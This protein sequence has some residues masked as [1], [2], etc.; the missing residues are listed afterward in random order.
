[1]S[2][3]HTPGSAEALTNPPLG[4]P[5]S[6]RDIVQTIALAM[7]QGYAPDEILAEDSPIVERIWAEATT[8][9]HRADSAGRALGDVLAER[10][11]QVEAKGWTPEHDDEHDGGQLAA[12]ASA[13]ALAA[14]DHL[15]P[16]SQGDGCYDEHGVPMMWPPDWQFRPSDPRRM[17]VKAGAL[18]LAEIER[19]ETNVG[20]KPTKE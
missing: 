17:L 5:E 13:Y 6:A 4:T 14:A 10:R 19:L 9:R 15:H 1:M 16:L 3:K 11:R 2:E 20:A 8:L 7:K 18:I 12:A